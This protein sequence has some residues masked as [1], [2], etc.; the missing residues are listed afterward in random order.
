MK[1]SELIKRLQELVDKH[2]DV[3]VYFDYD[4]KVEIVE[5]NNHEK[6]IELYMHDDE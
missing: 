1:A 5:Y 6:C 3:P 4:Y 2:E